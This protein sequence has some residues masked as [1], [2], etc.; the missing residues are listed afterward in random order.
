MKFICGIFTRYR[1]PLLEAFSCRPSVSPEPSAARMP[2]LIL[3]LSPTAYC[4]RE[5]QNSLFVLEYTSSRVWFLY[6]SYCKI[7]ETSALRS[8]ISSKLIFARCLGYFDPVWT[9]KDAVWSLVLLLY[10]LVAGCVLIQNARTQII[11]YVCTWRLLLWFFIEIFHFF[12][13]YLVVG[14]RYDFF[15]RFQ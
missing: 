2:L 1:M 5:R 10:F 4:C 15:F 12:N 6:S 13:R 3:W 9:N 8:R 7:I 11:S 14:S